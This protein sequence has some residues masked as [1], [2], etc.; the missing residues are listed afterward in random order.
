MN[1]NRSWMYER[2]DDRGF[3]NALFNS[4]VEEFMNYAISQPTSMGGTSIQCPCSKCKNRKYWNGDTVKLH[5]LKNG[6]VKDYYVWSRHGEPY[7][8]DGHV[9]HSSTNYSNISRGTDENNLMYNMMIDVAGPFTAAKAQRKDPTPAD[10]YL[11]THTVKHDKK[12]FITKK[13]EQNRVETLREERSTPIEG[14]DEHRVVDEDQL[15]LEADGGLDKKNKVYG[16]SSLQSVM[17]GLETEGSRYRGSNFNNEKYKQM[18]GE[19]QDMKNQVN[20]LQEMRNKELEEIR[21][22][23]EEMKSQLAIVFNNRNGN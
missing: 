23:M 22:Q 21:K 19:L 3:L 6:F 8:K 14:S 16:M 15:F 5:L 9:E 13:A 11:V 1:N 10:V 12:I 18:Q 20:E 7:I 4:G 2:I 17:Y